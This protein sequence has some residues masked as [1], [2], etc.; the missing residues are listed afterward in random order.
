MGKEICGIKGCEIP[1][2]GHLDLI[3]PMHQ[4]QSYMKE[5]AELREIV[6]R[7][8]D[9]V[10]RAYFE[11]MRTANSICIEKIDGVDNSEI[12]EIEAA[13]D[14]AWDGSDIRIELRHFD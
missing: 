2:F 7:L 9:L 10:R 5:T 11:G 14:D 13:I 4:K 6:E 12:C 8:K 1:V 3:C